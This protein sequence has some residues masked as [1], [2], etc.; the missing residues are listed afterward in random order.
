[1]S[2]TSLL[3]RLEKATDFVT[4]HYQIGKPPSLIAGFDLQRY[5]DEEQA[6]LIAFLAVIEPKLTWQQA[7]NGRWCPGV[8]AL[9]G[10]EHDL[11]ESWVCLQRALYEGDVALA[12]RTRRYLTLNQQ[13]KERIRDAVLDLPEQGLPEVDHCTDA[14]T[15]RWEGCTHYL[16]R[17]ALRSAKDH[18]R[19][20]IA[21]G[22]SIRRWEVDSYWMWLSVYEEVSPDTGQF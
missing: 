10:Q 1:M 2:L 22:V 15:L 21:L 6:R 16:S 12:R 19:Q 9:T 7:S 8:T 13:D 4:Q 3:R 14:P 18:I 17:A 20:D 5:D 11:F